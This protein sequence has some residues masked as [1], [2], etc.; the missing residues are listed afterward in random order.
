MDNT[1]SNRSMSKAMWFNERDQTWETIESESN[2][3]TECCFF[4]ATNNSHDTFIECY[5]C[6]SKGRNS[7]S[8]V[9]QNESNKQMTFTVQYNYVKDSDSNC[10]ITECILISQQHS[11]ENER[12]QLEQL[13]KKALFE[14]LK[15]DNENEQI[16]IHSIKQSQLR[17]SSPIKSPKQRSKKTKLNDTIVL[18]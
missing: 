17:C 8:N 11:N 10:K 14:W 3:Y 12:R 13:H 9:E 7:I 4:W 5:D 2:T 16:N 6:W 18:D 15:Q 1:Q